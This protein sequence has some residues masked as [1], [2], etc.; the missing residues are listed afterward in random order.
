MKHVHFTI[1]GY[2]H[3]RSLHWNF[4]YRCNGS[5]SDIL[6]CNFLLKM[7]HTIISW[8]TA[9]FLRSIL[10]IRRTA[11]FKSKTIKLIKFQKI[12]EEEKYFQYTQTPRTLYLQLHNKLSSA[13]TYLVT[14]NSTPNTLR[15]TAK[16]TCI[17]WSLPVWTAWPWIQR[18]YNTPELQ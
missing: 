1:F 12:L 11:A 5:Q 7:T 9:R 17:L 8:S 16:T 6:Q 2:G 15:S 4:S 10:C 18:H 14:L 3:V 13:S